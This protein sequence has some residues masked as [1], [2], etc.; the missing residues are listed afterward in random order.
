MTLL[1]RKSNVFLI[2]GWGVLLLLLGEESGPRH[3]SGTYELKPGRTK[4]TGAK[5]SL[6][7]PC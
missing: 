6:Y 2:I 4:G 3:A 7:I 1:K 5:T